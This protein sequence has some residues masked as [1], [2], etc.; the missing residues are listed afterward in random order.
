MKEKISAIYITKLF[1]YYFYF[2]GVHMESQENTIGTYSYNTLKNLLLNVHFA[3]CHYPPA[4][5]IHALWDENR[6]SIFDLIG[7]A[8]ARV[9]GKVSSSDKS[10]LSNGWITISPSNQTV[11]LTK[12]GYFQKLL[13]PGRYVVTAMHDGMTSLKKE[14][15]V[16]KDG[17][18]RVDF[19]LTKTVEP[20]HHTYAEMTAFLRKLVRDYPK[21]TKLTSIGRSVNGRNLWALEISDNPGEHEPGEPEFKYI[22]G[23]SIPLCFVMSVNYK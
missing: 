3:C 18:V 8:N 16:N 17:A 5:N 23:E 6:E 20:E 13:L 10:E 2:S 19:V 15:I 21:I 22:A 11:N 14:V 1:F 4:S 7:V 9:Y 12:S